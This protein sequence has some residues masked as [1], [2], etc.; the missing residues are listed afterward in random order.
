MRRGSLAPIAFVLVLAACTRSSA[1]LCP[2]VPS[3]TPSGSAP[4]GQTWI[5]TR[6][7]VNGVDQV[8]PLISRSFFA[9]PSSYVIESSDRWPWMGAAHRTAYF[10]SVAT[11]QRY[12]KTMDL[13][14]IDAVVY[15]P[16]AWSATPLEEQRDPAT[17]MET[18]GRLG[19][20]SG[21]DVVITPGLGLPAVAGAVC[22]ANPGESAEAAYLR[23]GI[24]GMAA[25]NADVVEIQ[26][27]SLQKEPDTYRDFVGSAAAQAREA[28]PDVVVVSGLRIRGEAVLEDVERTWAVSVGVTDGAYLAMQPDDAAGLL[29]WIAACASPSAGS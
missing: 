29:N 19:H 20:R 7:N 8:D 12:A 6:V 26:A 4:F 5:A 21:V 3:G 15:D 1:S 25:A 16:E 13:G 23:C 24:G 22:A 10:T 27:Q 28:N 17:A 11:F 18:F 14:N 2:A 9:V